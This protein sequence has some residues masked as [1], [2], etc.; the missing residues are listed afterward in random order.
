MNTTNDQVS[1]IPPYVL[2][3]QWYGFVHSLIEKMQIAYR[4]AQ[5]D[6]PQINQKT[7]AGRL[8]KKPSFVSRCLSGQ[9]NMTIRTIHDLAR[10]MECRLN[11]SFQ[12]L[13]SLPS[14]NYFLFSSRDKDGLKEIEEAISDPK[15]TTYN[16]KLKVSD[17]ERV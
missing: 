10:G 11:V 4:N 8:G 17:D 15:Q 2:E 6:D 1:R 9:Q 14:S 16:I 12:P 13:K 7:I 5:K 3:E